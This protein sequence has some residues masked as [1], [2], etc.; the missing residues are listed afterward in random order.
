VDDEQFLDAIAVSGSLPSPLIVFATF[1]GYLAGGLVGALVM[2]VA[3]FLPA[4]AI[5]LLGHRT[6]ER[7]V[8]APRIHRVLDLVTAAVVG[9]I[10]ATAV[11]L[12]GAAVDSV[13]S[14]VLL[15][16]CLLVLVTWR[17]R[18]AIVA[19]VAGSALLAALASQ[20]A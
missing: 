3:I 20:V 13:A 2:T 19:V 5:T 18:G 6:L 7:I 15:V 4:F 14:A 12:L 16:G 9:L 11:T 10:A 17:S 8:D 1:V